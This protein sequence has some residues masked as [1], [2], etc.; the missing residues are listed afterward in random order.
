MTT[1]KSHPGKGD[2][3]IPFEWW[4][5]IGPG[6]SDRPVRKPVKQTGNQNE[7]VYPHVKKVRGAGLRVQMSPVSG[8]TANGTFPHG[9][10]YRFQC[11]PMDQV[12]YTFGHDSQEYETVDAGTFSVAASPKLDIIQFKTLFVDEDFPWVL[13]GDFDEFEARDLLTKISK[14][15][16][17]FRLLLTHDY[18][19]SAEYNDV[20]TLTDYTRSEQEPFTVYADVTFKQYHEPTASSSS[21]KKRKGGKQWP[22][23]HK[24]TAKDTLYSLAKHFYGRASLARTIAN[25]NHIRSTHFNRPIVKLG[26]KW[27]VGAM[28]VIPKP[29]EVLWATHPGRGDKRT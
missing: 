18:T 19:R 4:N 16:T 17:P 10:H 9:Q 12:V 11:P 25:A 1:W 2:K 6:H 14:S 27:K 22:K 21:H 28:I 7:P 8:V 20:C 5:G 26:G 29:P 13:E 24:L 23:H 3:E 15:G